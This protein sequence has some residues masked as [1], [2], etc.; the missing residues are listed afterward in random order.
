MEYILSKRFE[1]EFAKLPKKIKIKAIQTL[2]VFTRNP[3]DGTLR[4]H[5]LNGTWKGYSSIDIT[6]DIRAIYFQ[7]D[8]NV[9][10]FDA[11]GSH[12]ELY[13]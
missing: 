9:V 4:K 13:E 10:R 1:K 12:S 6:G 7:L 2:S 3:N 11:I 5:Q 8:N